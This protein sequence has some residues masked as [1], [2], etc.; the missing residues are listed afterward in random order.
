MSTTKEK[1]ELLAEKSEEILR[2]GG[3]KAVARQHSLGKQTA[4][5]RLDMLFDPGSFVEIDRFVEHRCANYGMQGKKLPA[6]AVVTG[7]GK[8]AGRTVFAYAQDF[9]V[10]GGSLG[11]M[12]AAKI[13]KVMDMAV[14]SGVPI[15]GINDSGGARIQ[16]GIDALSGFGEIFRRNSLASGRIPQITLIMGPCAGGAVYSPALT[17]FVIMLEK[18]SQMFITGPSVIE[19][20]TGEEV[21]AEE[22]G[23]ADTHTTVSGVAHFS[24]GSEEEVFDIARKL[25]EYLPDNCNQKAK[26]L[27]Y[28]PKDEIRPELDDVIPDS[29]AKPYDIKDVIEQLADEDSFFETQ[30]YYA[31]NIVTG[32]LRVAGESVGVIAN[33]PYSCGGALDINASD[34]ASRF[35]QFCDA[36]RIP[37]LTLVDVPGFLPGVDQETG[38]IIRHGAKLLYVYSV[39]EVPKITVVLRK[40]YGG[41]YIGMCSKGLGAD[42]VMAWP[43][44]EIAVM[45]AEG[46]AKII[47][48]KEISEAEDQD[49]MY[50]QK[51]REYN[52]RFATPYAA[53]EHGYVDLVVRPSETRARIM[54]ALSVFADKERVGR[55]RGNMPL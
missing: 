13:C 27:P 12:H 7:Y 42:L 8:I 14:A 34:K 48:R 31:D 16:E 29:A 30:P 51:I 44:A 45:G 28:Q 39:A 53:A 35:I 43:T 11:E 47:F 20:I 19:A 32:F 37:L 41:A 26:K 40:A 1:I 38:G 49:A 23:G 50:A 52:E 21:T 3:E 10:S 24:A 2:C 18:N 9:T 4:R 22:L 46:A 5:E 36:F 25:L 33:Q 17:D 55:I 15:I 6:D 54:E